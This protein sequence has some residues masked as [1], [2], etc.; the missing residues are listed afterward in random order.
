MNAKTEEYESLIPKEERMMMMV[1]CMLVGREPTA[2][3]GG[4]GELSDAAIRL[5]RR[6]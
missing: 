4:R 1:I 2:M 6:M 3:K 5:Y